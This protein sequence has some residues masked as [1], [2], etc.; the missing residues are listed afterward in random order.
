[1]HKNDKI[2]QPID[3]GFEEVAKKN[4]FRKKAATKRKFSVRFASN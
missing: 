4:G 3:A 1:M 2:I